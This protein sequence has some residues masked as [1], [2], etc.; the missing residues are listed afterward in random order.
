V[1]S[2]RL[3]ARWVVPVD[4]PPIENGEVVVDEQGFL[5][6]VSPITGSNVGARDFGHAA[7]LPGLVN[8]H[9][10]LE[11]T[12][13]R[14]FLDDLPF[15]SWIRTLTALKTLLSR[16]DW[17][18]SATLGAAEMLAAG[19]TT[20]GDCADA[21]ASLD[22]L[23]ASGM[24][25]I[26]FR[27]AFGITPN[28]AA[29]DDIVAHLDNKITAMRAQVTDAGA[30]E[31][32]TIGL[33]PHAPYT[34]RAPLFA[35]LGKYASRNSLRQA[36]H[37]AETV[38]EDDLIRR[39]A[40]PFADMFARR[41]IA[42]TPP[43]TSPARYVDEAGGFPEGGA[44]TL[45]VHCV[46]TD[47]DDARLLSSRNVAVAHCPKSNGKLGAGVAP[48]TAWLAAGLTV[49]LGTDSVASNN[50]TDMWEEMRA[51]LFNARARAH[52]T[53]ALSSSQALH[54]ATLGGANALGLQNE[55]GSLTPNKRA[56]LCV[57]DLSG[58]HL[59]PA[60]EDDPVAALVYGA[61]AGDTLL[62]MVGGRVL[63]DA[64]RQRRG[65]GAF[66]TLPNLADLRAHGRGVRR[67]LREGYERDT[68]GAAT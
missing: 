65:E 21:G 24:R 58:P 33:S 7:I 45:A 59:F 3:R 36:I 17:V 68:V 66:P 49:G 18:V 52:D 54:L 60:G 16:E 46:H 28:E 64:G 4:G 20:V 5:V 29:V 35:A 43:R 39:G 38:A 62:T 15:F 42:W 12:L 8:V 41:G 19:I 6:S 63:Y 14:G 9:S 37:V 2:T 50:S 32:V 51:A 67:R 61:R 34:V 10:H 23:L 31:R 55:I 1:G 11:Y 56:D 48:L 26:V 44:P 25:G 27:E 30:G 53:G 22:A 40:G 47:A 13:F 57:V